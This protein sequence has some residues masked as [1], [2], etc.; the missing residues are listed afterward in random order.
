MTPEELI[1]SCQDPQVQ[2]VHRQ[3]VALKLLARG[4]R[5]KQ[6][7][8]AADMSQ[9]K[10]NELRRGLMPKDWQA[11]PPM[12]AATILRRPW[13]RAGASLLVGVYQRIADSEGS[14]SD[15]WDQFLESYDIYEVLANS[16]RE[17]WPILAIDDACTI[18]MSF[19]RGLIDSAT[20]EHHETRYLIAPDYDRAWG[21]P[22]CSLATGEW[23]LPSDS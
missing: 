2:S 10:V 15:P 23:S 18:F 5:P 16:F 12:S 21:C 8:I 7:A 14:V 1:R 9:W 13:L 11:R 22:Y 6:V 20:C 19:Q 4:L 17:M 3:G